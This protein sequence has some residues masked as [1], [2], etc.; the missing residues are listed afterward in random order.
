MLIFLKAAL[1]VASVLLALHFKFRKNPVLA[2]IPHHMWPILGMIPDLPTSL[3]SLIPILRSWCE[4][5]PGIG[6]G[7]ILWFH[8]VMVSTAE[9]VEPVMTAKGF[10]SKGLDYDS[11]RPWFGEGL[12]TSSGSRWHKHRKLITPTFHFSILDQFLPVFRKH[13]NALVKHLNQSVGQQVDVWPLVADTTLDVICQTAM[14][15]TLVAGRGADSAYRAAVQEMGNL[16]QQR[17]IQPWL[18]SDFLFKLSGLRTKQD[19]IL[20]VLHGFTRDVITKRRAE[21]QQAKSEASNTS[22]DDNLSTPGRRLAF[23]DLLLASADNGADLSTEDIREEVDTFMFE[24]H[25]TTTSAIN[26]ALYN[27]AT[28]PNVQQKI[29]QELDDVLGSSDGPSTRE[30]FG[31]L[32]YL[33]RVIKESMRLFPPVTLFSRRTYETC[34][35]RQYEIPP[36]TDVIIFPYMIHRDPEYWP[37]P[38]NFDPDRFLP[39]A[40][41]G[42]HPFSYVPFSA[43]LRNCI[44][45]RFA[46]LEVKA[47]LAAILRSF[48]IESDEKYDDLVFKM[49]LTL[50]KDGPL[51]ITF[52]SRAEH[53][54]AAR[55]SRG[56]RAG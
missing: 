46:M 31:Q 38:D 28:H 22:D 33:E 10:L 44:G 30:E 53:S 24:G 29:G 16:V 27:I 4:F 42:R 37:D 56:D 13:S 11:L 41:K 43:G 49:S 3:T 12:L 5:I 20:S 48:W 26:W 52:H 9:Y 19:R 21:L 51:N 17:T 14:G 50:Q 34:H 18:R 40:V 15:V 25:D 36:E 54:T 6:Y 23:L 7:F 2:R 55:Q 35:I 8:Y 1:L 32:K 47:V 39:E 45:Q